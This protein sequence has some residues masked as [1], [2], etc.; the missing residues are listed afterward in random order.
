MS[1]LYATIP[2]KLLKVFSEDINFFFKS[3]VGKHIGFSKTS[4]YWTSNGAGRRYFIKQTLANTVSSL[5]NKCFFIINNIVFKQDI[6]MPV[7]IGL[8]VFFISLNL[9]I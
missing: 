3:K 5:I 4:I 6:C 9:S 7:G 2:H 1:I 8:I